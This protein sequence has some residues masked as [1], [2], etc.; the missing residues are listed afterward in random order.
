MIDM[1][2]NLLRVFTEITA[3][4]SPARNTIYRAQRFPYDWIPQL[5]R[6]EE[7]AVVPP[8]LRE[9]RIPAQ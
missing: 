7:R 2:G 1:N 4:P 9:F 6:P 5:E 3:V 8:N